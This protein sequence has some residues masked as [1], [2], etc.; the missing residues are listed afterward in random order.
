MHASRVCGEGAGYVTE[1]GQ[2]DCHSGRQN[3][4]I[5]ILS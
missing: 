1:V 3:Y 2:L 5:C 4:V